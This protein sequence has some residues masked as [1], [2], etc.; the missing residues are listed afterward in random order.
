MALLNSIHAFWSAYAL[1]I[2]WEAASAIEERVCELLP[3][4]MLARVDGKSPVE[5]LSAKD[6]S[7]VRT[8]AIHLLH[9]TPN[10]LHKFVRIIVAALQKERQ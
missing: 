1:Y 5:Y 4:L 9:E 8:S 6:Q 10:T 7:F 3:A 2:K